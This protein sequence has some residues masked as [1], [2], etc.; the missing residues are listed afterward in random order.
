M[1]DWGQLDEVWGTDFFF[2]CNLIFY[3]FIKH[4]DPKQLGGGKD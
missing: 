1:I 4:S 3:C 2:C